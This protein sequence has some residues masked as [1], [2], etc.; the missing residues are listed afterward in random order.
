MLRSAGIEAVL[1]YGARH[2]TVSRELEAHVWVTVAGEPVIGGE[3]ASDFAAI[4]KYP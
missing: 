1:H 4:A 2:A 3:E